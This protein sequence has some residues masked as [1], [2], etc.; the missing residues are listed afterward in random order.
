ML[1][2]G[3][4]EK[5][6]GGGCVCN[7]ERGWRV[8]GVDGGLCRRGW[9]GWGHQFQDG[10]FSLMLIWYWIDI[11]DLCL[12]I[13]IRL[14]ICYYGILFWSVFVN[15]YDNGR[16]LLKVCKNVR[17]GS[18]LSTHSPQESKSCTIDSTLGI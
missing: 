5:K 17:L 15:V 14:G 10:G 9:C 11:K 13:L 16:R 7:E 8:E 2:D 3:S 6:G 18:I 1:K 12:E 4:W